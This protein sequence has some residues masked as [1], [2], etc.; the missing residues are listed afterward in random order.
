VTGW[1]GEAWRFGAIGG[2]GF[3]VD[4]SVLTWLV[5]VNGWGLYESRALSFGLAVT[6]TWYLNR[7]FTFASRAGTDRRREYGR[8]FAVQTLGALINLGV[9]VAIVAAVPAVAAYPVV[10]LAVGSGAAMVFNF[11]AARRFAFSGVKATG[12]RF[13]P[14]EGTRNDVQSRQP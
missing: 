5:S 10:P 14:L 7:R 9:Y 3:L 6:A 4:A 1:R 2:V 11:L 12:P 8:Y 13:S